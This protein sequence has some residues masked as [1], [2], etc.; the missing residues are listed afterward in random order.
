MTP[1]D[2][3]LDL[4]DNPGARSALMLLCHCTPTDGAKIFERLGGPVVELPEASVDE[5]G[6]TLEGEG[7]GG[8]D[9]RSGNGA[10][11]FCAVSLDGVPLRPDGDK[12]A[13]WASSGTVRTR[14]ASA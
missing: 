3:S 9:P 11:G 7:G 2:E 6:R 4:F 13:C 5:G 14:T 12:G 10:G 8:G 1:V